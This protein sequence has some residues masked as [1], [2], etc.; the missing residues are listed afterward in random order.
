MLETIAMSVAGTTL[1]IFL[2]SNSDMG[3]YKH[4]PKQIGLHCR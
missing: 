1:A 4:D 3:G 2:S